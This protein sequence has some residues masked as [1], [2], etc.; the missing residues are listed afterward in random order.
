MPC[1]LTWPRPS[2]KSLINTYAHIYIS[3]W[4][5]TDIDQKLLL[6]KRYQTVLLERVHSA[7]CMVLSRVPQGTVLSPLLFLIRYTYN[8]EH[9]QSILNTFRLHAD[10]ALLYTMI[11]STTNCIS[12][13]SDLSTSQKQTETCLIQPN[14][15][16]VPTN[17]ALLMLT[18]Y[19]M[20]YDHIMQKV[21]TAKYLGVTFDCHLNQKSRINIITKLCSSIKAFLKRNTIF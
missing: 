1:F 20:L 7:P 8:N 2:T 10:D 5:H 21:T 15:N 9:P 18:I 11:N 14:V 6:N 4:V 3:L 13:Q 19:A 12:L 16:R 17:T